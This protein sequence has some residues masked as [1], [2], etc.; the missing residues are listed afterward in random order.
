[1]LHIRWL[2]RKAKVKLFFK[3]YGSMITSVIPGL[4]AR[5]IDPGSRHLSKR[6]YL[7]PEKNPG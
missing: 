6:F 5:D 1:M 3:I 7:F 2:E 4:L